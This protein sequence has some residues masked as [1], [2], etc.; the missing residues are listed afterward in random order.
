L[1]AKALMIAQKAHKG[2]KDKGGN[3]YI[4]H[5]LTVAAMVYTEKEK[6]VALSHD[7]L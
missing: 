5:P 6:I 2:Q 1:L 7:V 4:N 3:E